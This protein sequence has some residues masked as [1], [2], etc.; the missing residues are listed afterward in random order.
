VLLGA[1]RRA[2]SQSELELQ[3]ARLIDY[4]RERGI[5][6]TAEVAAG[7]HSAIETAERALSATGVIA[8]YDGGVEPV[9]HVADTGR[10]AASYYRNPAIHFL[11]SRA[12]ADLSQRAA[13]TAPDRDMRTV[14]RC[15]C[16][17]FLKFEFF[18]RRATPSVRDRA[19]VTAASRERA[20]GLPPLLAARPRIPLDSLSESYWVGP[21]R[22]G[23]CPA[24]HRHRAPASC[25][26]LSRDRPPAPAPGPRPIPE[27]FSNT[28]FTNALK[29]LENLPAEQTPAG[30]RPGNP[31]MTAETPARDLNFDPA[32]HDEGVTGPEQRAAQ[33]SM[34][35]PSPPSRASQQAERAARGA[36][37]RSQAGV[38][39]PDI[40]RG[41]TRG[42]PLH[43]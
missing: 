41:P 20:A 43:A 17:E 34:R 30:H 3:A 25:A 42:G 1:G 37:R 26:P 32:R 10:H 40:G 15:A 9:M 35:A 23:S 5:G 4:A 6:M 18:F 39:A 27:L 36:Q 2:L 8:R 19:R 33:R 7:A 24:P 14:S 21:R 13:P 12:I 38:G 29:P 11:L 16:A 22:S 31:E 28:N